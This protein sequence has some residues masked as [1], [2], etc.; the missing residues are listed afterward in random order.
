MA[1]Q[2]RFTN[3]VGGPLGGQQAPGKKDFYVQVCD[4]LTKKKELHDY[5]YNPTTNTYQYKG[6]R[7]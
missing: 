7:K 2:N 4:D 6:V 3:C 5:Q 1:E